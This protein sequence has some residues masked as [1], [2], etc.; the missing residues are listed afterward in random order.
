M[1][2]S[3]YHAFVEMMCMAAQ[4]SMDTSYGAQSMRQHAAT[5]GLSLPM[6]EAVTIPP[7]PRAAARAAAARY[8]ESSYQSFPDDA[9]QHQANSQQQLPSAQR[10]Y[11]YHRESL[12]RMGLTRT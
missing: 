2:F 9:K 3:D 1:C 7:H 12:E 6:A 10:S 4:E 11:P 8:S 5:S